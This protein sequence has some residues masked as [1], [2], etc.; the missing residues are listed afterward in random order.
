MSH[1][2]LINLRDAQARHKGPGVPSPCVSICELDERQGQCK[3]CY[4]SLQEIA[5][6]GQLSDDDKLD[7]WRRIEARQTAPA[8]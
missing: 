6:W 1:E 7:V 3:G 2:P 4:R 8:G 5:V